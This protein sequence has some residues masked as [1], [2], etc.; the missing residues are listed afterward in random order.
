MAVTP[1]V[2]LAWVVL[3]LPVLWSGC[4]TRTSRN[5]PAL[6]PGAPPTTSGAPSVDWA[7]PRE[8][9]A[10]PNPLTATPTN[11]SQGK[12]LFSRYCT[13][14]HGTRGRGD[15]P[16]AHVWGRLP[17]DLAHPERQQRLTDGEIFWRISS[18]HRQGADV[19]MPGLADRLGAE[20]R[21]RIVLHV[22]ALG[23]AR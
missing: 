9:A 3:L 10:R 17:K 22:R 23:A 8:E 19:I 7:V 6:P 18:G 15:G 5:P 2:R 20:D 14:C 11:L 13:A 21:W 1:R 16:V 12:K 4:A